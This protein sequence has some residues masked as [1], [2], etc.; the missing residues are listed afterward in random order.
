MIKLAE[1]EHRALANTLRDR[2]INSVSGRKARLNRE[3]DDVLNIAESNAIL[4]H[5]NQF[6]V[7]NP[8]S[9]GGIQGKRATR[10][11]RDMDEIPS[12][13][14]NHKRKRKAADDIG[15]PAPTRRHLDNGFSTP[16]WTTE[17]MA[18]A[19]NKGSDKPLYSLEKLFTERELHMTYN[20]AALAA[21]SYI[22]T[23]K[24]RKISSRSSSNDADSGSNDG[25]VQNTGDGDAENAAD[26]E[27]LSAPLMDR[28][29]SHATRSTRGA[30]LGGNII[31]STGIEIVSDLNAP[32]NF[33]RLAAQIPKMPPP[34]ASIMQKGYQKDAANSPPAAGSDELA[35]DLQ[36]MEQLKAINETGGPGRSLELDREVLAAAVAEPGK[37][38]AWLP[39][40]K[41]D[42]A[43]K[44]TIAGGNIVGEESQGGVPM[45]KEN[46]M[47]GSDVGGIPMSRS[48]TDQGAKKRGRGL[49]IV[50]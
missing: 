48:G 49:A 50:S 14:E 31:T 32:G 33:P 27:P 23:H 38:E 46:S 36:R 12:F 28:Q 18:R 19:A 16:I 30:A 4:M 21:H 3:K 43:A 47:G 24:A 22:V 25:D 42:G 17:Q 7:A 34:L 20:Q 41:I 40:A 6:V 37:Y 39:S 2:L 44:K 10:H 35:L 26:D 8:S 29:Y 5:P 13:P 15:S 45:S 1:E 11:R 9:P